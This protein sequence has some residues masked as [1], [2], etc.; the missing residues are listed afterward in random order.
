MDI[1]TKLI[2]NKHEITDIIYLVALQG[3]NFIAPILVLPYLMVVLGAE[4]FG[5]ISFALAVCQYLMVLVDFGFYLSTTKRIALVKEDKEALNRI[6]AATFYCKMGL[7]ALSFLILVAVASIPKF[8][9]Y[10]PALFAMFS[11]VIG[12]AF[13]FTFLFQGLGQIRWISIFNG[14][15]KLSVLPLTFVLVHG[16]E[17]YLIAALLQGGVS[18]VAAIISIIMIICKRWVGMPRFCLSDCKVEMKDSLPIFVSNTASTLYVFGFVLILG[19]F[20]TPAEVGR[21]AASDKI[22]RALIAVTLSP[23]IQAFYPAVS[24]MSV[25]EW[26]RAKSLVNLL[27]AM[28]VLGMVAVIVAANVVAPYMPKWLGEDYAG[29]ET[30]IRILSFATIF[31][32]A[33]GICGQLG[34]LGMGSNRQKKEFSKVYVKASFVAITSVLALSPFYYGVGA[35]FAI[36]ITEIFVGVYMVVLYLKMIHDHNKGIVI[37]ADAPDKI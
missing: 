32:S 25:N 17:D 21:Y 3:L 8:A 19:I 12:N 26:G 23:V 33:G 28:L 31:I 1:K 35:A 24:R 15:A 13:L 29:T 4:K 36:L 6:F 37:K 2:E 27:L 5:Y 20:A 7:L 16:P 18:I 22:I 9:V 34:L 14:I 11:I 30:M 10:R